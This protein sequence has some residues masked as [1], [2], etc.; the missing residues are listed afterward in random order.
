MSQNELPTPAFS[1]SNNSPEADMR[2]WRHVAQTTA[3][4]ILIFSPDTDIYN[5]GLSLL[6]KLPQKDVIVQ[7]NVPHS[8]VCSYVIMRNLMKALE[9]DPDLANIPKPSLGKVFQMLYITSGCDYVS[10][11]A[12]L[13]KAAFFNAFFQ[14][15]SFITGQNMCG[16]LSNS[17]EDMMQKVFLLLSG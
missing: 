2:I 15:A 4:R 16:M 17:S 12:G 10:Y 14:H 9:L 1:F 3:R 5:I 7:V 6:E 11:F 13:G 8:P